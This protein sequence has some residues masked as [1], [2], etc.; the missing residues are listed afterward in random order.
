MGQSFSGG[1]VSTAQ[2]TQQRKSR[3]PHNVD[4]HK[5][6]AKQAAKNRKSTWNTVLMWGILSFI[7]YFWTGTIST[8]I[9]VLI[10]LPVSFL[11]VVSILSF[12]IGKPFTARASSFFIP[13]VMKSIDELFT[14]VRSE[15]LKNVH[16]SVLDVGCGD[17]PY[18]KYY[19]KSHQLKKIVFLE[20]NV[21]QHPLL[22]QNID[23]MT[24]QH[25]TTL[26]KVGTTAPL[27]H[28]FS[29]DL[30]HLC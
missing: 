21:F 2:K 23:R 4:I 22:Q 26:G 15:L 29:H 28:V 25:P 8:T 10:A 30:S 24:Q 1:E 18:L 19:A 16:G 14:D 7:I 9:V 6:R 11:L 12:V 17:G 13:R 5:F 3:L 20:P 27:C